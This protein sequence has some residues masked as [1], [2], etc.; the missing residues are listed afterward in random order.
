MIGDKRWL[1]RYQY[2]Y[3]AYV[4]IAMNRGTLARTWESYAAEH[5]FRELVSITRF[6]ET[7]FKL[8][9]DISKAH[10]SCPLVTRGG[11]HSLCLVRD[12]VDLADVI[13]RALT[14]LKEHDHTAW[15]L[16]SRYIKRGKWEY[17][18]FGLNPSEGAELVADS[19]VFLFQG[20]TQKLSCVRVLS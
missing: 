8:G 12:L 17:S 18:R 16:V 11:F 14:A 2:G 1:E 13:K 6:L 4:E 7:A 10:E 9:L 15:R 19:K 20:L 3:T 5:L